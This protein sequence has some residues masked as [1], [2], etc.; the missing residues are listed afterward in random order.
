MCPSGYALA[1]DA[2]VT[3]FTAATSRIAP[4]GAIDVAAF[5]ADDGRS[6]PMEAAA[7]IDDEGAVS[8]GAAAVANGTARPERMIRGFLDGVGDEV[9]MVVAGFSVA[10]EQLVARLVLA[11]VAAAAEREGG[12]PQSVA[13]AH[14]T[15][16]GGHRVHALR[17]AL[18]E[19]GAGDVELV[20]AAV[21]AAHVLPETERESGVMAIYDLGGSGFEASIL[22]GGVLLGT[23]RQS[24]GG[25]DIDESLLQHLL[26]TAPALMPGQEEVSRDD[27]LALRRAAVQAR[28]TLSLE[29][30]AVVPVHGGDQPASVRLTRAEL[31]GLAAEPLGSTLDALERVLESTGIDESAIDR[32]LLVGGASRT[33]LVVQRLSERFDRPLI[34]PDDPQAAVAE[35]CARIAWAANERLDLVASQPAASPSR[36]PQP[37]DAM[38]HT[39]DAVGVRHPRRLGTEPRQA[40]SRLS[41]PYTAAAALVAASVLVAGG[42]VLGTTARLGSDTDEPSEPVLAGSQDPLSL[43]RSA[44]T[45]FTTAAA[46]NSPGEAGVEGSPEETD[47]A[48][49]DED[50]RGPRVTPLDSTGDAPTAPTR[51][52][53]GMGPSGAPSRDPSTASGDDDASAAQDPSPRPTTDPAPSGDPAPS[54][55]PAPSGETTTTPD[56]TPTTDPAPTDPEPTTDPQPTTAP[57]PTPDPGAA[58]EPTPAPEPSPQPEPEPS[59]APIAEPAA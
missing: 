25:G 28:E 47:A 1:I 3:C 20:P 56:P 7:F 45:G 19:C 39:T 41:I 49:V 57:E 38:P 14:P 5:A 30:E 46:P 9:P 33:P 27:A 42:M 40:V 32:I 36:V 26:Q 29:S 53:G 55:E 22:R 10:A 43:D 37:S 17:K 48:G 54:P 58:P 51:T 6:A 23:C 59:G 13:V 16:W 18:R 52:A 21:A 11:I 15:G 2:G 50:G 34:V 31:E 4:S 35:G 24:V 8:F 44:S 12:P